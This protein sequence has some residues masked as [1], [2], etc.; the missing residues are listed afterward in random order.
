MFRCVRHFHE[1]VVI[2]QMPLDSGVWSMGGLTSE[3]PK[4]S[5][6]TLWSFCF[7]R[8]Q[9]PLPAVMRLF[10][11]CFKTIF[12]FLLEGTVLEGRYLFSKLP[13][14]PNTSLCREIIGVKS[15]HDLS[16]NYKITTLMRRFIYHKNSR[17]LLML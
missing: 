11:S 2:H 13:T 9:S 12:F 1:N 6:Y 14:C 16:T 3:E 8:A 17:A 10:F 15:Q 7:P 5:P 4:P